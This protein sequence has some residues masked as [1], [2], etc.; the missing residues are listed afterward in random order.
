M[1]D[2]RTM[3]TWSTRDIATGKLEVSNYNHP[4]CDYSF[5]NYMRSKQVIGG[6]YRKWNNWQ[7]GLG[8][9]SL[10]DSLCRH[11]EVLKLLY[12]WFRVFETK[13]DWVVDLIVLQKDYI[14]DDTAFDFCEEKD[15]VTECNA[16]RFN[17]SW[18]QLDYLS[19][20]YIVWVQNNETNS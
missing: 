13:K 1:E 17:V 19:D 6:Q 14:F 20:N 7:K 2:F 16:I 9:E 12:A 5:N 18:L 4:L 15:I 11:M 8:R 3:P 10:F